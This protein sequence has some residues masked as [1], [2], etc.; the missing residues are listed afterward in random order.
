MATSNKPVLVFEES[1]G[2]KNKRV[3]GPTTSLVEGV[4]E[5]SGL[6]GE[7]RLRDGNQIT[8]RGRE[9]FGAIR[10]ESRW[11]SRFIRV[12]CKPRGNDTAFEYSLVPPAGVDANM[13]FD[14]LS[15]VDPVTLRVDDSLAVPLALAS[16]VLDLPPSAS[17]VPEPWLEFEGGDSGSDISKEVVVPPEEVAKGLV[18]AEAISAGFQ[19]L[20][21]EVA[22]RALVAVA[23][24]AK[25]GR[26]GRDESRGS[27]VEMLDLTGVAADPSSD[28]EDEDAAFRAVI[29][30]MRKRFGY[31][32]KEEGASGGYRITPTGERRLYE[33]KDS[34]GEEV[35][36]KLAGEGWRRADGREVGVVCKE[37][38]G[39]LLPDALARIRELVSSY[40]EAEKQVREFDALIG[41][42]DSEID[43]LDNEVVKLKSKEED[44]EER[45]KT[46][47]KEAGEARSKRVELVG[48]LSRKRLE[49]REL[50]DLKAPHEREMIRTGS[51]LS[52]MGSK[53]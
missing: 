25:D 12:W 33:V 49:K 3:I 5:E 44:L 46:L 43:G 21:R 38:S 17:L 48:T 41:V 2:V 26:S 10:V 42:L 23:L 20:S 39:T 22:D 13:A 14:I 45:I 16:R 18:K 29:S 9:R 37:V 32:E 11:K 30:S 36:R 52:G 27:V 40:E 8:K 6:D 24:V 15:R 19:P 53:R 47:Q 50:E 1:I 51:V 35:A 28:Y 4:L 31:L 34:F 7:W